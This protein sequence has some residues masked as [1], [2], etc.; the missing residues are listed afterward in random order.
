MIKAEHLRRAVDGLQQQFVAL[1][2]PEAL[3]RNSSR[4]KL[5]MSRAL[6]YRLIASPALPEAPL[7]RAGLLVT[8]CV[9]YVSGFCK[10]ELVACLPGRSGH[11]RQRGKSARSHRA[12]LSL[13]G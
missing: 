13:R 9:L 10:A 4:R 8:M 7:L 5:S 1:H 12:G 3:L 11:A 6:F 2:G